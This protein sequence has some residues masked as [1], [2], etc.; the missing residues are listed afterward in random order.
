DLETVDSEELALT[1]FAN[2]HPCYDL[3]PASCKLVVFDINLNVS[4]A[5]YALVQN[6]IR[7]APLWSIDKH[8]FAGLLTVT[9][10]LRVLQKY[11]HSPELDLKEIEDQKISNWKN[12]LGDSDKPTIQVEPDTS[13]LAS[14]AIL[15][16]HHIHHLPVVDPITGNILFVLTSKRI[17]RFIASYVRKDVIGNQFLQQTIEQCQVGTYENVPH[18]TFE[19]TL[20][21]VVELFMGNNV[22]ALPIVNEKNQVI[23]IY[24]KSDVFSIADDQMY[25]DLNVTVKKVIEHRKEV[26]QYLQT[27]SSSERLCDVV[28]RMVDTGTHCMVVVSDRKELKGVISITDVIDFLILRPFCTLVLFLLLLLIVFII[29]IIITFAIVLR[30]WCFF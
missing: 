18:V 26:R 4:K 14:A 27:C 8:D 23:D 3:M 30:A 7:S 28:A 5:F 20:V 29:V 12:I 21:E 11:Y 25:T 17:L 16:R 10:F 24:N 19:M 2:T 15:A 1:R 13:L 6:S 22:S 9:D